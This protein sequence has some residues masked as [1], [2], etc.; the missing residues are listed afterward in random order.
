MRYISLQSIE[1][2]PESPTAVDPDGWGME[3]ERR[4][5]VERRPGHTVDDSSET[6]TRFINPNLIRP[7]EDVWLA[8][9]GPRAA[10]TADP[11]AHRTRLEGAL[12]AAV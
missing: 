11:T 3:V 1:R 9:S 4:N 6:G 10:E 8:D 2:I 5:E 12:N 7:L